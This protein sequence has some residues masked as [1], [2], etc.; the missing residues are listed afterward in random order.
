MGALPF[1]DLQRINP[2]FSGFI[3]GCELTEPKSTGKLP[4]MQRDEPRTGDRGEDWGRA[5]RRSRHALARVGRRRARPLHRP[6][7]PGAGR[8]QLPWST[9]LGPPTHPS[10]SRSREREQTAD[11]GRGTAIHAA[12]VSRAS[13][14][15]RRGGDRHATV[16]PSRS[17]RCRLRRR[18]LA[19]CRD[20]SAGAA[21]N[22]LVDSRVEGARG[23]LGTAPGRCDGGRQ[24]G[25]T[26]AAISP[27][28]SEDLGSGRGARTGPSVPPLRARTTMALNGVT[29]LER[30]VSR[31]VVR[32][33][34][35][36][37]TEHL[38]KRP[39]GSRVP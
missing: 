31:L 5:A 9:A 18:A 33:E 2:R 26:Q 38:L 39:L 17:A 4:L 21:A 8:A 22:V 32:A 23:C 11:A 15:R 14:A 3:R 12:T 27:Q 7:R 37:T 29:E 16:S 24:D 35:E 1:F 34:E 6:G 19:T 28:A 36:N 13:P 10:N 30:G 25:E 20:R